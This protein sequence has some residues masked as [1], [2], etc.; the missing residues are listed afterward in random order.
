MA[1]GSPTSSFGGSP[2]T[3]A[4]SPFGTTS[5]F[6]GSPTTAGGFGGFGGPTVG[7]NED[8]VVGSALGSAKPPSAP[9]PSPSPGLPPLP[10]A[11]G[12]DSGFRDAIEAIRERLRQ[13]VQGLS[14]AERAKRNAGLRAGVDRRLAVANRDISARA[15]GDTSGLAFRRS[16]A[17]AAGSAAGNLGTGIA[18]LDEQE[19]IKNQEIAEGRLRTEAGLTGLELTSDQIALQRELGVGALANERAR[20]GFEGERLGFEEQRLGFEGERLDLNRSGQDLQRQLGFLNA[21]QPFVGGFNPE[22][23]QGIIDRLLGNIG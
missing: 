5:S 15:G 18:S 16:A 10:S 12:G 3:G 20:V 17:A 8:K 2:T 6:G 11:S 23:F 4:P 7:G 21:A 13:P 9:P 19:R 22:Q 1:F 14:D